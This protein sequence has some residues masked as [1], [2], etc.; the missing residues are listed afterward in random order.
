MMYTQEEKNKIHDNLDKIKEYLETLQPQIRE[1]ITIDFGEFKTY[2]NGDREKEFH[3]S[4]DKENISGR[5]GGL[6]MEYAREH[7]S[8]STSASIYSRLDYAVALIQNWHHVKMEIN[9]RIA[10]QNTTIAAIN[11]FEV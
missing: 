8:S 9:T 2:V 11:N 3:L 6:Y 10:Q 4:V 5:S 7:T 1:R